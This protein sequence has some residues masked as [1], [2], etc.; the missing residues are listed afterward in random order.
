[1]EKAIR[2]IEHYAWLGP[3]LVSSLSAADPARNNTLVQTALQAGLASYA[4]WL[5][6]SWEL[7]VVDP[8]GLLEGVYMAIRDRGA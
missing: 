2:R 7:G 6:T 1:M 4:R 5:A 8:R 3:S